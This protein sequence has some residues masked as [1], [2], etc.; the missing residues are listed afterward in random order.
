MLTLVHHKRLLMS[1]TF[2]AIVASK[3]FLPSMLSLVTQQFYA[4]AVVLSAVTAHVRIFTAVQAF[5]H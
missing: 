1:E 2:S 3:W 4:T 5:V